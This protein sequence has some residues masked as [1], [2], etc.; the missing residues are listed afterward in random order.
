MSKKIKTS[1]VVKESKRFVLSKKMVG[2]NLIIS[3]T[4]KTGKK[5]KYDHDGVYSINQEKLENME[6]WNKYG[7]Y[8]NSNNLPTWSRECEVK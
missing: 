4:T 3:V 6:C 7:N 8:T 1:Q 2:E 5:F